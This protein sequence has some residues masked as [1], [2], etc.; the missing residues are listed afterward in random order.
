METKQVNIKTLVIAA[1][2]V[3]LIELASRAAFASSLLALGLT[4]LAQILLML[5]VVRAAGEGIA[6]I[7]LDRSKWFH[8]LRRGFLWSAAF[9]AL[10]L[11]AMVLF[12]LAGL[13]LLSTIRTPLPREAHTLTLFFIVGGVVAPVAEEILFRGLVYGFFRRWGA[14]L[15]VI[16]STA[17]FTIAHPFQNLPL[18]QIVGGLLFASAYELEKNLLVPIT[19]HAL[20]NLAIFALSV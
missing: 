5:W 10:A 17:L 18:T 9:G 20:G 15:A 11:A 7:G 4:R 19:I 12:A 6:S 8:G 14:I 2:G 16:L 1:S 13:D 3:L